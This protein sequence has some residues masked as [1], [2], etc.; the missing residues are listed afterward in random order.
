MRPQSTPAPQVQIHSP[1]IRSIPQHKLHQTPTT[2]T[3]PQ[4]GPHLPS[5]AFPPTSTPTARHTTNPSVPC[6]GRGLVIPNVRKARAGGGGDSGRASGGRLWHGSAVRRPPVWRPGRPL[7]FG[8]LGIA[9][10]RLRILWKVSRRERRWPLTKRH[11]KKCNDARLLHRAHP[12]R[13][14]RRFRPHDPQLDQA[15]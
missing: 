1:P 2:P 8:L 14:S 13:L 6:L 5:Q 12:R 15:R 9:E 4:K 7:T 10:K 11:G 3:Q